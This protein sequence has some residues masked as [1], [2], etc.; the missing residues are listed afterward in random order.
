MLLR[1]TARM[2]DGWFP[3]GSPEVNRPKL[4]A[5]HMY[6]DE[7]GR[8]SHDFGIDARISIRD[9]RPEDWPRWFQEWQELGATHL[10][11]ETMSAG[12][13]SVRGHIDAIRRFKEVVGL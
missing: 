9:S 1:R 3:Q 7:A 5:L 2:A 10:E 6:L 13:N 12:L 8:N 4:E 11:V